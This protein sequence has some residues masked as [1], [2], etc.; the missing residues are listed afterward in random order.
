MMKNEKYDYN[1]FL[2]G[3]IIEIIIEFIISIVEEILFQYFLLLF[4]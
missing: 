3:I 4:F 2:K 1:S